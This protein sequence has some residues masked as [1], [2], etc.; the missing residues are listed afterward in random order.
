V[1]A[2][3]VQMAAGGVAIGAACGALAVWMIGKASRK[4]EHSD[5]VPCP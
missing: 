3:F 4:I 1:A 5:T 2:Y